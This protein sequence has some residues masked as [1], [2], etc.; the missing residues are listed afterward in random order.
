MKKL[1]LSALLSLLLTLSCL[2]AAQAREILLDAADGPDLSARIAELSYTASDTLQL[3]GRFTSLETTFPEKAR[4]VLAPGAVVYGVLAFPRG[5]TLTGVYERGEGLPQVFGGVRADAPLTVGELALFGYL[6]LGDPEDSLAESA[7]E[8]VALRLEG[9]LRV[10]AAGD[11]IALY[12]RG[13]ILLAEGADVFVENV[14]R[15]DSV[16]VGE[17]LRLA[18]RAG[19]EIRTD[20]PTSEAMCYLYDTLELG[21][22]ASLNAS[23]GGDS[24]AVWADTVLLGE[25]SDL[26]AKSWS[27]YGVGLNTQVLKTGPDARLWTEAPRAGIVLRGFADWEDLLEEGGEEPVSGHIALDASTLL[28]ANVL[29]FDGNFAFTEPLAFTYT[30]A[31]PPA[32]CQAF[33]EYRV[34]GYQDFYRPQ[35]MEKDWDDEDGNCCPPT[36]VN[37]REWDWDIA[38]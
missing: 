11:E 22:Y 26:T 3:R 31:E 2:A 33:Q 7:G 8:D 1:V 27:C 28:D 6:H 4:V 23:A 17:N 12:S 5:G 29:L 38:E 21:Q 16:V 25:D 14:S 18:A 13:D 24:C 36:P 35:P 37:W 32:L 15:G 9:Y 30:A 34:L 10:L 20:A 19:L